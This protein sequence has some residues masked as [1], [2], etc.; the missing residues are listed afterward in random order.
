MCGGTSI[1]GKPSQRSPWMTEI[2]LP[3]T[4]V[5]VAFFYGFHQLAQ[6]TATNRELRVALVQPGIPQTLIWNPAND[7]AR[8][9]DLLHLSENALTNKPDVVVWPEAALPGLP[10]YQEEFG[11]PI[12]TLAHDWHQGMDDHRRR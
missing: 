11:L 9:Q 1:L 8:F 10:H 6:P 4:V 12:L 5:V 2:I 7:M 3:F